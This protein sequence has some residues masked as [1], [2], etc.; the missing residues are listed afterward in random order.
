MA[1]RAVRPH[2]Q[3][4]L[5]HDSGYQ[6]LAQPAVRH[7]AAALQR[8]IV[9]RFP[10]RSLGRVCGELVEVIDD[11]GA[12]HGRRDRGIGIVRVLSRVVSIGIGSLIAVAAV[13]ALGDAIG[14]PGDVH[15]ADWVPLLESLVNDIV[16]GGVAI[17]FLLAVPARLER[18]RVLKVLHRLRSLAHVIDMHQLTK[19]PDRLRR[20]A[21]GGGAFDMTRE[22]LT[23]Y[24][25]YSSEMLALVG[26]SA[27]L[28]AE[29]TSDGAILEAVGGIE[30]L[31][32]DMSRK[33]WQKLAIVQATRLP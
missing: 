27:A 13:V 33:V 29:G 21:P 10:D 24:L 15:A 4:G 20:G 18:A 12:D 22:E 31:T 9:A 30:E 28:F 11:I 7:S 26:K 25:E 1:R 14:R 5:T 19:V 17:A 23:I 16:F 3:P 32:S 8:R 6:H 2:P